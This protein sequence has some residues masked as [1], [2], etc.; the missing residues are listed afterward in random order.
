MEKCE[1]I[2][3]NTLD[4][5]IICE[6]KAKLADALG[7]RVEKAYIFGSFA[8]ENAKEHSD[9][10]VILI[11]DTKHSFLERS[12]EFLDLHD[13]WSSVDIIVYTNQEFSKLTTD[14]SPGFWSSVTSELEEII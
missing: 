8:R 2:F 13:I 10:D 9:L 4:K 6:T 7:N 14:P 1:I 3:S 5:K 11:K 12:E